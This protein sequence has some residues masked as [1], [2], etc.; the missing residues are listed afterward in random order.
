LFIRTLL[1]HSFAMSDTL[2]GYAMARRWEL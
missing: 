2:D 1:R